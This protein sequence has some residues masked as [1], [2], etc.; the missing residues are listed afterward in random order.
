MNTF[1]REFL[2]GFLFLLAVM[3]LAAA[4]VLLSPFFL[5]AAFFLRIILIFLFVVVGIW[6]LGKAII[7]I[8]TYLSRTR[9]DQKPTGQL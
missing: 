2:I 4:A 1:F 5:V 6:L 3:V 9:G 8:W 7:G